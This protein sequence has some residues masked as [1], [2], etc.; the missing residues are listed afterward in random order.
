MD[1]LKRVKRTLKATIYDL[2]ERAEDPELELAKF[3]EACEVALGELRAEIE[4]AQLR[5]DGLIR[6]LAD[7]RIT[8][9]DWMAQ[10][11]R[12][13]G[14][15]RKDAAL[16][17]LRCRRQTLEAVRTAEE[18]L[19]DTDS[20]LAALHGDA[21]ALE[22][23]LKNTLQEQKRLSIRLRGAEADKRVGAVLGRPDRSEAIR[24]KLQERIFAGQAVGEASRQMFRNTPE[25][26]FR[27]L[28]AQPSLEDELAELMKK[29]KKK[30]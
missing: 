29:V 20:L 28:E 11:E 12:S 15:D 5:R 27:E 18:G 6:E 9:D 3:V 26:R 8:A 21:E 13:A 2:M 25:A 17:A 7:H 4:G 16:E 19:A 14:E 24:E 10:A 1:L 23:K 22:E 30:S